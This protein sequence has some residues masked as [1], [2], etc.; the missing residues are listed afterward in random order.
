MMSTMTVRAAPTLLL[1]FAFA[2]GACGGGSPKPAAPTVARVV[3][4]A[5]APIATSE[6]PR[7]A[8]P[9]VWMALP[10]PSRSLARVRPLLAVAPGAS[11]MLDAALEKARPFDLEQPV[12]FAARGRSQMMSVGVGAEVAEMLRKASSES[13]VVFE[14]GGAS[15]FGCVY[16]GPFD[17]ELVRFVPERVV[18]SD[19]HFEGT[20]SGFAELSRA[21]KAG[22]GE[23]PP[24]K[25][26][27]DAKAL[28]T[29]ATMFDLDR[30]AF[31][32]TLDATPELQASFH[33][34][35][36]GE[37]PTALAAPV[38]PPPAGFAALPEDAEIAVFAHAPSAAQS[39]RLRDLFF[40]WI[41]LGETP[42]C[43]DVQKAERAELEK[44]LFTGGSV[45]VGAGFDRGRIE[46]ASEAL[47][48]APEDAK[49][50]ET[51]RLAAGGW[52][53][54]GLEEP[55]A[56]WQAGLE[57]LEH[58]T[59]PARHPE[60]PASKVTVT[61][62]F[63]ADARLPTGTVEITTSR[64]ATKTAPAS[65]QVVLVA[66]DRSTGTERTWIAFAADAKLARTKLQRVLAGPG[67]RPRALPARL[68]MPAS[69]GA[70]VT[71]AGAAWLFAGDSDKT[72][73]LAP[74][75]TKMLAARARP[76]GG[77]TPIVV[78]VAPAREGS[79]GELGVRVSFD[80]AAVADVASFF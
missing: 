59:C 25:G 32:L 5:A 74:L 31:D 15:R 64:P 30:I 18:S 4:V 16:G 48:K 49:R 60:R 78:Q 61:R 68:T 27:D 28:L 8:P 72:A 23:A 44:L 73:S 65:V 10:R 36:A 39:R 24:A 54:V 50:L 51:M 3:P 75:A 7:P 38:A 69:L 1:A 63:P 21:K 12:F 55:A 11:A 33:T 20:P 6:P 43:V 70:L 9:E 41:E 79:G 80:P 53:I 66:P 37:G 67:A 58:L 13:C 71:P 45:V 77:R 56:R 35:G 2:S 52:G 19:V 62:K 29:A 40:G 47:A 26:E 42:A 34:R 17:A 57:A 14:Q 76:T 22:R 46:R